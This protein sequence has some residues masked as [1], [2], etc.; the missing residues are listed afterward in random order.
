MGEYR[1]ITPYT[2][3]VKT[4]PI[5]SKM[6]VYVRTFFLCMAIALLSLLFV[7]SKYDGVSYSAGL[8]EVK[9]PA[10]N[11]N[12]AKAKQRPATAGSHEVR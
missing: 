4:R 3:E 12:G 7:F 2:S 6:R 5:H 9:A 10:K 8:K 11:F 1:H